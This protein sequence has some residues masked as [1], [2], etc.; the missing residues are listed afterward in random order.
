M[1]ATL[2]LIESGLKPQQ[3][4]EA[5]LHEKNLEE[6]WIGS[7]KVYVP[8]DM[9]IRRALKYAKRV[10]LHSVNLMMP[11]GNIQKVRG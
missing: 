3:F 9:P 8:A 6:L 4:K 2:Q 10:E 5:F 1:I 7:R 11:D